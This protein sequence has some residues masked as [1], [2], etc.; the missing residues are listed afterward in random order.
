MLQIFLP[1]GPSKSAMSY[2]IFLNK[3]SAD[4]EFKLLSELYAQVVSE[5]KALCEAVQRN[6]D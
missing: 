6:L 4:E 3:N 5:D 2:Q 1:R